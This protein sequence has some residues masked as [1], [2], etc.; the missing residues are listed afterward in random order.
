M[1]IFFLVHAALAEVAA[2]AATSKLE[3]EAKD[4]GKLVK[5]IDQNRD[6]IVKLG[7]RV[8]GGPT[9]ARVPSGHCP[10]RG[11]GGCCGCGAL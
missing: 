9:L 1:C 8:F 10:R 2:Y 6:A 11:R 7:K 4:M 5:A 3:D